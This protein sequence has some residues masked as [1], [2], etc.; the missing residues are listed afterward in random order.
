MPGRR[1]RRQI[2][3]ICLTDDSVQIGCS[4]GLG[5][6]RV[7]G[8]LRLG[9]SLSAQHLVPFASYLGEFTREHPGVDLR[10]HYTAAL[11]MI[12]MLESG[13]LDCVIGPAL[14]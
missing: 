10:L 8:T 6:R 2:R 13:E 7:L 4:S 11:T 9:I 1:R 3:S 5:R 14:N 12:S